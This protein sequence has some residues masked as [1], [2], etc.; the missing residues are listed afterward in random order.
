MPTITDIEIQKK[1][2]DRVSV[3]L[4]GEFFCGLDTFT[5]QKH[6]LSIGKQVSKEKLLEAVFESEV[7]SA[8]EKSMR[9]IESRLKSEKEIRDYLDGKTYKEEVIEATVDRLK[10]YNYI[11]DGEFCRQY[12]N[13]Y[14]NRWGRKKIEYM[15]KSLV[16]DK[17]VFNNALEE[18][19]CQ[20]EVCYKLAIK[21]IGSKDFDYTQK[22]KT[23]SHLMQKGFIS[24]V[25]KEALSRINNINE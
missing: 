22:Q 21:H 10:R 12:I 17:E 9:Q 5:M 19:P 11:N 2:K 3:F 6:F 16:L 24:D 4:D 23:F 20:V 14:L 13:S 25:I 8:F 15:L 1:N 18:V 7:E